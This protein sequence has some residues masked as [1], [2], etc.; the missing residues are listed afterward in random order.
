MKTKLRT[1][2]VLDEKLL[3]EA[4]DYTGIRKTSELLNEGLRGLIQTEAA[5]RLI[6]LGGSEPG[7]KAPPRRRPPRFINK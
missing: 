7:L 3:A 1:T 6:A 2:V 5:R 4:Q